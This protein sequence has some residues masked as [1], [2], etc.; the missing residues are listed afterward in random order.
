MSRK[1]VCL[2]AHVSVLSLRPF[3]GAAPAPLPTF[4]QASEGA[5]AQRLIL[6]T[7]SGVLHIVSSL[8]TYNKL[9]P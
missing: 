5:T 8:D 4:W 7:S 1:G 2:L 3:L 9:Q 6:R